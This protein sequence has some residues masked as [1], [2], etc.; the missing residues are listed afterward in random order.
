MLFF[1]ILSDDEDSKIPMSSSL[2]LS[3]SFIVS[4]VISSFTF[5][6]FVFVS[7]LFFEVFVRKNSKN[8]PQKKKNIGAKNYT[9]ALVLICVGV[10]GLNPV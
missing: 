3:L 4:V 7:L 2:S 10:F 5:S 8:L 1:F 9:F 6:D